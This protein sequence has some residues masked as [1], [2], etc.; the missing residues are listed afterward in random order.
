MYLHT[1]FEGIPIT[2]IEENGSGNFTVNS[3]DVISTP[4]SIGTGDVFSHTFPNDLVPDQRLDMYVDGKWM[5]A[6]WVGNVTKG[7]KYI[8]VTASA[9]YNGKT[10]TKVRSWDP[11]Q[12]EQTIQQFDLSNLDDMREDI[13]AAIKTPTAFKITEN[14]AEPYGNILKY[15]FNNRP[16]AYYNQ[17]GLAL[18]THLS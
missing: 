16:A 2:R 3:S 18:R 11:A 6:N 12:R 13:L 17:D 14:T 8:N 15:G 4:L 1:D 10:Y 7:A 5:P 9:A